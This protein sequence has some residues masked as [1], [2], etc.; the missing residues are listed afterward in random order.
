MKISRFLNQHVTSIL[1]SE[2]FKDWPVER[3]T[4]S[5]LEEPIIQYVFKGHG[6]ALRCDREDRISVIFLRT[7]IHDSLHESLC[8]IPLTWTRRQTLDHFGTPSKSGEKVHDP[9]L[10]EYGAWDRFARSN[11]AIHVEYRVGCDEIKR[12]TLMRGDV[13]P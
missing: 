13:V 10:G 9:I 4:E 6:L 1:E 2:P 11:Y 12:I 5:E 7:S 3:S 8:E